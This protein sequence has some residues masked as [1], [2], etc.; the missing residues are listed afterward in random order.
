MWLVAVLELEQSGLVSRSTPETGA[1]LLLTKGSTEVQRAQN[2]FVGSDG[3]V[4]G[5]FVT[6]T[7]ESSAQSYVTMW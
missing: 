4:V 6:A 7:N 3:R 2:D 1:R 5:Y